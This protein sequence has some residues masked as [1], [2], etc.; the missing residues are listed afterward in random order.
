[1]DDGPQGSENLS[2]KILGRLSLTLEEVVALVEWGAYSGG[3]YG[4]AWR[5]KKR[6]FR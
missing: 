1:V 3:A 2:E 6:N 5:R 4:A